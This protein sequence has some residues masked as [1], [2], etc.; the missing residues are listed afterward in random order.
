[1]YWIV[2]LRDNQVDVFSDP[3]P[4]TGQ[5]A[6]HLDYHPG[7]TLPQVIAGQLVGQVAVADLL[8]GA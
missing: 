2:N 5:Y 4:A 3:D 8:P 6:C 7:E 1:V